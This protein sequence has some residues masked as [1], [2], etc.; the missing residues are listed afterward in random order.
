[1]YSNIEHGGLFNFQKCQGHTI[2]VYVRIFTVFTWCM[3]THQMGIHPLP[4]PPY[5]LK[6]STANIH[7][8]TIVD[9]ERAKQI[10]SWKLS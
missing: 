1:M 9:G 10:I 8:H 2:V 4:L 7:V 6:N 5:A 3:L